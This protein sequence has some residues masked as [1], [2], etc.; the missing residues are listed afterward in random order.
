MEESYR[1]ASCGHGSATP[2]FGSP[3][4]FSQRACL[5]VYVCYSC[6]L[7]AGFAQTKASRAAI[8]LLEPRLFGWPLLLIHLCQMRLWLDRHGV[9]RRYTEVDSLLIVHDLTESHSSCVCR[10]QLPD[11]ETR[12]AT[13]SLLDHESQTVC[14][15]SLVCHQDFL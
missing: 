14:L 10:W 5:H 2:C 12:E 7:A 4:A 11:A 8:G 15:S 6:F 1:S 9:E 13:N 3:T